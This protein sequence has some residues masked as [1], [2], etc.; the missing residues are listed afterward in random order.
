MG[1]LGIFGGL[2]L[3]TG[4]ML[5]YY[6][7]TNPNLRQNIGNASDFR[8]IASGVTA[9]LSTWFYMF[10]LGQVYYAFK[11]VKPIFRNIIIFCFGSILIAYG[12][13]HGAYIAIATSAKLAVQHNLDIKTTTLLASEANETLRLFIYPIF[14]VLS[15]LFISKVWKRKTL[16]PRWIIL[17]FP[18]IPF[19]AKDYITKYLSDSLW[20][21]I[22]GGYFNLILVVFFSASTIALWNVKKDSHAVNSSNHLGEKLR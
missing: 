13:I 17:F 15:F 2:I 4:D 20:I 6:H 3:F 18:L 21:I 7:P 10:G 22:E 12:I 8:I 5:F 9:L 11:P 19:L 1:I 14:A 16:Y